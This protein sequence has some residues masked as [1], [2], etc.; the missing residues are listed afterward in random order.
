MK[1]K[2][3]LKQVGMF[4]FMVFGLLIVS[5]LLSLIF[6]GFRWFS[7]FQSFVNRTAYGFIIGLCFGIGNWILGVNTGKRLNWSK[8]PKKANMISLLSFIFYG[9]SVS[10][11]VPYFFSVYVWR[12]SG[13]L[14][15]THVIN[16]AFVAIT[17]DL[18]IISIYYSQYLVHFWGKT[19]QKTEEL[20]RENLLAKYE[21][22]KNQVN[23]HF[24]FNSLNTLSGLVEQHP[25]KAPEFI[26]KLSDIYRYVLEQREK[27]L[28]PLENELQFVKNFFYLLKIRFGNGIHLNQNISDSQDIQIAPLGLQMLV[29]NA[30][31]HN[32]ISD[33]KQLSINLELE[34]G[35]IVVRNNILKKSSSISS[36]PVGLENLKSRY[37]Y[38]TGKPVIVNVT[39]YYFEVKLPILKTVEV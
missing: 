15:Y 39:E 34:D 31:K 1:R 25:E 2:I 16:N 35:Y 19:I 14:I 12:L 11:A 13:D 10:L 22:L 6:S 38:L 17:V 23:P 30:I 5:A 21:A 32:V 27:E 24:L 36:N 8:N 37:T 18:I 28:T 26:K 20:K 29:E 9:I 4:I 7:S 3:A 33:E